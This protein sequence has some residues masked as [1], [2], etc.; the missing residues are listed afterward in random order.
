MDKLE[1]SI[2]YLVY[3]FGAGRFGK[4]RLHKALWFA[5]RNAWL[6]TGEAITGAKYIKMPKGPFIKD[7][8]NIV[9]RMQESGKLKVS[10]TEY[11]GRTT[12]VYN[13]VCDPSVFTDELTGEER[14]ILDN[15]GAFVS[16]FE[17]EEKVS[18]AT[19]DRLFDALPLHAPMPIWTAI[20]AK[21]RSD[22]SPDHL[23]AAE[24]KLQKILAGQK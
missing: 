11:L 1:A 4:V 23:K 22:I 18:D 21:C 16:S 10:T 19:H 15:S 14:S 20:E 13:V 7:L 3:K 8:E 6:L 12:Y 2:G 5:D 24:E 17:T 9:M